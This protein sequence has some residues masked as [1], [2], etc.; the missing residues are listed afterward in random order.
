MERQAWLPLLCAIAL[1]AL[2]HLSLI[3]GVQIGTHGSA[4]AGRIEVR[5]SSVARPQKLHR[6]LPAAPANASAAQTVPP[7]ASEPVRATASTEDVTAA[8]RPEEDKL[9]P[10]LDVPVI[11]DPVWYEARDLD[12]FPRPL[13]PV[14][15][16]YPT[17]AGESM[18]G[19]LTLALRID[20]YGT[21]QEAQ[22]VKA[23]PP[24]YFEEAALT[25][26]RSAH[27]V[28][29]QRDGHPVRSVIAVRV[30]VGPPRTPGPEQEAAR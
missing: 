4:P 23:E 28:P 21:V 20:E 5:L 16:E 3:Y 30:R 18:R 22:V 1:S 7:T 11:V 9:R 19:E 14:V 27:F 26:F 29:G 6:L 12:L 13:N 15:P 17:A 2:L 24:G 25:A 8:R 10:E